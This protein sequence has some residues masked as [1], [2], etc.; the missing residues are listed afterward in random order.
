M[1][2]DHDDLAALRRRA[3]VARGVGREKLSDLLRWHRIPGGL[4]YLRRYGL[5][6][7]LRRLFPQLRLYSSWVK[8]YDTLTLEDNAAIRQHIERLPS[9]PLISV[10][11]PVVT[12]DRAL[13]ARAIA[14]VAAQLYPDWEL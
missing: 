11:L 12:D 2:A 8:A 4:R 10:L 3:I 1:T 7:L 5:L 13:L 14:G 9:R 6:V